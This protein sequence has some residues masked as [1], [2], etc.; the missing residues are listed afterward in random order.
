LGKSQC[1]TSQSQSLTSYQSAEIMNEKMDHIH[2]SSLI[3]NL[4]DD[5][6]IIDSGA[7]RHMTRDQVILSSLNE[8]KTSY[9]VEIGD[10]NTYPVNGIGQASIK[11]KT[12]NNVH[13]S[14]VLYVPILENNIV[15]ISFLEDK[16]NRIPFIDGEVLS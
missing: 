5:M 13:L 6:W 12:C 1:L 11:L 3:G 2:Y 4:E 7:S 14:N 16:G 10:K 8:K 9:K 15:S